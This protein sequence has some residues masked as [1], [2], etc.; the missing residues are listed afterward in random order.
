M[1]TYIHNGACTVKFSIVFTHFRGTFEKDKLRIQRTFEHFYQVWDSFEKVV[2]NTDHKLH[3]LKKHPTIF[4][5][6]RNPFVL[7]MTKE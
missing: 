6:F 4:H 5:L 3:L 7:S 2:S 1:V